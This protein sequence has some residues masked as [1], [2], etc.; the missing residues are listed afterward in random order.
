MRRSDN[1]GDGARLLRAAER[2]IHELHDFFMTWLGGMRPRD[3]AALDRLEAALA[4][5]FSM[6]TPDG[7]RLSRPAVVG[8]IAAAH[9]ARGAAFRIWI[10]DVEPL[11]V[12]PPHALIGYVERQHADGRDS[13]RRASVL[14][15][16]DPSGPNGLRW[17]AVHETWLAD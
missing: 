15:R 5:G 16:V 14:F 13:A 10:T 12:E 4:P 7:R 1:P 9:G 17:L 2:E 3:Q 8:W 6:V 11:H